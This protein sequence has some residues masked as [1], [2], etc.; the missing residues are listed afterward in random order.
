MTG[1]LYGRGKDGHRA[2]ISNH[3]HLDPRWTMRSFVCTRSEAGYGVWSCS[4][5]PIATAKVCSWRAWVWGPDERRRK[6]EE[7]ARKSKISSKEK[8]KKKKSKEQRTKNREQ[9]RGDDGN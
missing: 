4:G 1:L 9:Q 2:G 7:A 6:C 3:C 8:M 5:W